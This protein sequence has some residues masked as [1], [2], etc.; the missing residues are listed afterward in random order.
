MEIIQYRRNKKEGHE[1]YEFINK[2]D[3]DKHMGRKKVFPGTFG[4]TS[5]DQSVFRSST[6]AH[7]S[8]TS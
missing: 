3:T 7:T 1:G 6:R 4:S 2:T 8:P 5:K